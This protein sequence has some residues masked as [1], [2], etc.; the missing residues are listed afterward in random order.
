MRKKIKKK[1][2]KT[3]DPFYTTE[4]YGQGKCPFNMEYHKFFN[5]VEGRDQILFLYK[6]KRSDSIV[7]YRFLR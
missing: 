4:T 7:K 3:S 2:H 1:S 5:P 6:D